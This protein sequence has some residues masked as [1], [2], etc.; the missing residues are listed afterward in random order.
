MPEG[1]VKMRHAAD[2]ARYETRRDSRGHRRADLALAFLYFSFS[3]LTGE[4]MNEPHYLCYW[5]NGYGQTTHEVHALQWFTP[6]CGYNHADAWRISE[7]AIGELLD[8]TDL[9]GQHYVVRVS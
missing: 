3:L 6:D 8:F 9:S 5:G 1:A 4:P 7:L 2:A